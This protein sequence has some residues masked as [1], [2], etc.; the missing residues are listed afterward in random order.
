MG[1]LTKVFSREFTPKI[2]LFLLGFCV[3]G[4]TVSYFTY[5]NSSTAG[6]ISFAFTIGLFTFFLLV[7][8]PSKNDLDKKD[9]VGV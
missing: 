3:F 7:I 4:S 6:L 9:G 2:G 5:L 1:D 8:K